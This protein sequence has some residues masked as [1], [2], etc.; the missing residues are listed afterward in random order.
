MV[1][2]DVEFSK[3]SV[4]APY[5]II[6]SPDACSSLAW[7]HVKGLDGVGTGSELSIF[8]LEKNSSS[9]LHHDLPLFFFFEM[10]MLYSLALRVCWQPPKICAQ[11]N[12]KK[13]KPLTITKN[14]E[15]L[16]TLQLLLHLPP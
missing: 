6:T 7:L 15:Y 1:L 16:P 14:L 2:Y 8:P 5:L 11:E 12:K 13:R 4:D 10:V 3:W 9:N